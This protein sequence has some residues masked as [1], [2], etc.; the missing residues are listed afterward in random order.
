MEFPGI[1]GLQ[2]RTKM[3]ITVGS[4]PP[5][6]VRVRMT[7]ERTAGFL[8]SMSSFSEMA[9]CAA[10]R[11][12]LVSERTASRLRSCKGDFK[13][14]ERSLAS[15]CLI[16]SNDHRACILVTSSWDWS[17]AMAT[18]STAKVL[19]SEIGRSEI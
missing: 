1:S 8:S 16:P 15:Y 4:A 18:R 7:W 10:L 13:S 2:A 19:V 9:I 5:A 6:S 3:S 11:E 14:K 12:K 17:E